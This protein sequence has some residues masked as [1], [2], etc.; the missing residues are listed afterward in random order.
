M[1]SGTTYSNW[2]HRIMGVNML[3]GWRPEGICNY[4]SCLHGGEGDMDVN[5]IQG[6]IQSVSKSRMRVGTT[7][8]KQSKK[9]Q[10]VIRWK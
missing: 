4:N 5:R 1:K 10:H 6:C 9:Y 8:V 7:S 2:D 3:S